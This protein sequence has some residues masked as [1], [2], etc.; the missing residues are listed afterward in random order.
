MVTIQF[1]WLFNFTH[2]QHWK[3]QTVPYAFYQKIYGW[4]QQNNNIKPTIAGHGL[5][6]KVLD[7]Y[8][9]KNGGLLNSTKDD[10][11]PSKIAD[12]IITNDWNSNIQN[13]DTLIYVKETSVCLLARKEPTAWEPSLN[14]TAKDTVIQGNFYTMLEIPAKEL[15]NQPVSVDVSFNIQSDNYP[16][17][18]F[19]VCSAT[20]ADNEKVAYTDVNLQTVKS[21]IR[22][23]NTIHRRL[24]FEAIPANAEKL[25]IYLWVLKNKKGVTLSNVEIKLQK[26]V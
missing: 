25:D 22:V 16:F 6:G 9:Y 19:L 3:N 26:S 21:D 7:Y 18:G 13:Y 20:T 11:S 24:F 2:I 5:L 4:Q 15:V 14:E 1:I 12:F 10:T 8:D 23:R 17:L